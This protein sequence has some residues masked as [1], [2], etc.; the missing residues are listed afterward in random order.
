MSRTL[1]PTPVK[2]DFD[3]SCHS[4]KS[5]HSMLVIPICDLV[6][7]HRSSLVFD[8]ISNC[9]SVILRTWFDDC[10]VMGLDVGRRNFLN[11]SKN[12]LDL[13]QSARMCIRFPTNSYVARLL[14]ALQSLTSR[15][16]CR[17][18]PYQCRS[19]D[20]IE[21][22]ERTK[23]R[24]NNCPGLGISYFCHIDIKLKYLSK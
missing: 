16:R 12:L 24:R 9:C 18:K 7:V 4:N 3:K 5:W 21:C 22:S 19:Q 11:H 8:C 15:L 1:P 20:C 13:M 14:A 23:D 2:C 6:I 17:H 10:S